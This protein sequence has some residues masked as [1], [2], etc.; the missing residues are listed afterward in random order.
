MELDAVPDPRARWTNCIYTYFATGNLPSE[1]TELKP[2]ME[3]TR[4]YV[5]CSSGSS[6]V[7]RP[8]HALVAAFRTSAECSFLA[9]GGL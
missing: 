1:T 7:L 8:P 4:P 3:L 6:F 5:P 9:N 2:G